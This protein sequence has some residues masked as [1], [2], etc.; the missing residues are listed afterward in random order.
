[1]SQAT[2]WELAWMVRVLGGLRRRVSRE[3]VNELEECLAMPHG[4]WLAAVE[5]AKL[6]GA[7]GELEQNTVVRMWNTAPKVFQVDLVVAAA[8]M[9]ETAPWARKFVAAAVR[10][11]IHAVAVAAG[12][13]RAK[14]RRLLE[15][16]EGDRATEELTR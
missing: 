1:M 2:E 13:G 8:H 11:P 4:R 10:E 14:Y 7:R 5:V 15:S 16:G 6:V 9:V 3:V 12:I